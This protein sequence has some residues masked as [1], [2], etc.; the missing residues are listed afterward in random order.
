MSQ[1]S[2]MMVDAVMTVFAIY[3]IRLQGDEPLAHDP[4][5]WD[6][7][8]RVGELQGHG[9]W[10]LLSRFPSRRQ[11][12]PDWGTTLVE[13]SRKELLTLYPPD[14][15]MPWF[16]DEAAAQHQQLEQLPE[17]SYAIAIVEC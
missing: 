7:Y 17:G 1:G 5:W 14:V 8:D 2:D 12:V 10:E 3:L 15:G 13:L 4:E 16:A 9:G 11:H 6:K